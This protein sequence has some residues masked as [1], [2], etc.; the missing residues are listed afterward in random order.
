ML[1]WDIITVMFMIFKII[2]GENITISTFLKKPNNKYSS[3]L[4]GLMLPVHI[5]LSMR[6]EMLWF[7][8]VLILLLK[9]IW[10]LL[11]RIIWKI[12]IHHFYH[13]KWDQQSLHK[14]IRCTV[15]LI[16]IKWVVLLQELLIH[17]LKNSK[18]VIKLSE[19]IN[20]KKRKIVHHY[21]LTYLFTSN[22]MIKMNT[23]ML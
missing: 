4:E 6:R 20:P 19:K 3:K 2:F 12:T 14:I 9:V 13:K 18:F 21:L 22:L 23:K 15:K 10:C 16:S 7:L 1:K 11:T 8:L 17:M 5:I